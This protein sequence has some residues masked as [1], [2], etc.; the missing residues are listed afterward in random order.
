MNIFIRKLFRKV[1]SIRLNHFSGSIL[2]TRVR[3]LEKYNIKVLLDVGANRGQ[4]AYYTRKAGYKNKIISFEPLLSAYEILNVFTRNDANWEAVNM[5]L[6]N[7]EGSIDINIS[8]NSYSSSILEMM[9]EHLRIAP[10]SAFVGK[11]AV[12]MYRLDNV[13][14]RYTKDL[15]TTFLKIDTQGF[16][17]NILEGAE[18]CLKQIKGMQ[19]ELS[20]IELYKGEALFF[21][22]L[23][24][25]CDKGFTLYTIEPGIYDKNS[26]QLLQVD[27]IFYRI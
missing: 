25:V 21:E 15:N 12:E 16:E 20:F 22:M 23:K 24:F 5:A 10:Q 4:F 13:I 11:Q 19:L 2:K 18:N 14:D 7:R 8:A 3:H 1:N 26:G 17:K 6:G 9:P 27:A